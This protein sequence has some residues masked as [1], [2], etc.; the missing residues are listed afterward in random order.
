MRMRFFAVVSMGAL[1]AG[2]LFAKEKTVGVFV[3][4]ADNKSQGIAP[5]PAAIG[6]GDD[7]ERNLYWGTEEGLKGVFDHSKKWK[8]VE[9]RETPGGPVVLSRRTYQRAD[10][11]VLLVARAYRGSQMKQCIQDYEG[12]IAHGGYDLVIFVGHDGLMD[13]QLPM[14]ARAGDQPKKPDCAALCC[15]SEQYFKDHIVAAGGRPVVLTTQLMYPGSF[16]VA[17]LV[18]TWAAGGSTAELR[19]SAGAAYA[20]N[21]RISTKAGMGV[22]AVI[23]E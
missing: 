1:L 14:P 8:L 2:P 22:F 6:N 19:A 23:K 11:E 3:A 13:F 9:H 7:A 10:G 4:L 18:E 16:V 20:A 5:I 17:A 21:Q 15:I 12:A